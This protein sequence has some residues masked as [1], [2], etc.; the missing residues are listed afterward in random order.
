MSLLAAVACA[1][2]AAG[3]FAE[4]GPGPGRGRGAGYG[5]MWNPATVETVRG[6]IVKV[7]R[8]PSPGGAGGGVH[9]DLKTATE[10]IAVHL[11]PD[12]YVTRDRMA[13]DPTD[14]IEVKGSRVTVDGKPAIIAGEV[15]KGSATLVLREADGAP[16]WRGGRR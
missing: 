3:A 12:W 2:V 16:V 4:Q 14:E 13:L 9:L 7:D 6:E 11:G 1:A 5:R 8:V 10:T 15:R